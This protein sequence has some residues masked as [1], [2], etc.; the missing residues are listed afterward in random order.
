[1]QIIISGIPIDIQKKNIKNMHLYVKPPDG[2]VIISAPQTMD[3]KVIEVYARTNLSWI[4]SQI[5]QFQNQ[6]R[7]SKRQYVSGETI[8]VWGKQ[9]FIQFIPDSKK[10]NFLLQGDIAYL[11]MNKESTVKQREAFIRE[12]YRL[13]LKEEIKRLLPKWERI[14]GLHCESWQTKYMVTRWGTCNVEKKKLWFNL[15]L[16][17]KP[18]ECLEFVILHELIHFHTRKHDATFI[19]YM[20]LYMSNWRDI[21]NELNDRKLDYYDAH[22]ESPL[23][24]LIDAERY[25]EINNAVLRHLENDPDLEKNDVLPSDVAIENVVHIEQPREG[26][27]SFD[28]IASCDIETVARKNNGQLHFIEKWASAHCEV[29]IGIELTD[30]SVVSVERTEVQEES[31]YDHF[32]GELVPIISCD[33]FDR[34]ATRFLEKYYPL[35][36]EKSV[37]VPIRQIAGDMQLTIIEDT[38]LSE[39]LSIFGIIV[40][41]DG[42]IVGTNKKIL[43]RKA[44]R[45]TVYI[46]PRVYCEKT[47]GTVNSMI[48]HECYH[49]YRHQP[50]H[51]LMKMI[52]AKDDIGK[53]IHCAIQPN[54]KD[55]EKWKAA[56]WLEWQANSV[57]LHILMPMQTCRQ[58]IDQLMHEHFD[59]AEPTNK[60][61]ALERVIDELAQYYG[62][63]RQ[64][65]KIRMRQLGYHN[66]DDAYT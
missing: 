22:D 16:A 5:R 38:R 20:D 46:D 2:H 44:K 13:L 60:P 32:S 14:T 57:A 10:N 50:Y 53:A 55:T 61:F 45:G 19:A 34:E 30:F 23:K 31:D 41:E 51:T 39:E 33:D 54:T 17:Q 66:V 11:F 15:Q 27:I 29:S 62:V 43:V 49:W 64:A 12:Q 7:S 1:M 36:L 65:A 9:Y 37:P 4:K 52:G 40:F 28:V 59:N 63:S 18:I 47:C 3:D 42:N 26:I 25:E 21:R 24:K 35:A 58:T 8:Y 6:S 56:D 48:A